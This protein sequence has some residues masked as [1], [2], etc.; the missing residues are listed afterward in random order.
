MISILNPKLALFFLALFSQFV[1][2]GTDLSSRVVIVLTPLVIDGLWYTLIAFA[3]SSMAVIDKLR[4]NAVWIDRVCG[5]LL[6]MLA[7]RVIVTV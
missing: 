5:V 7:V 3:L 2:L 1:A 6:L 4:G